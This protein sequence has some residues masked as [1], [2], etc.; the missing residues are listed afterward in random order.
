MLAPPLLVSYS[1]LEDY[2]SALSP[3]IRKMYEEEIRAL[4]DSQLPPVV[5]SRCLSVLFGYSTKFV[6]AL[7]LRNYKYY[8][9]FTIRKGNK[10]RKI[11]APRVALKVIQKWFGHHL[12]ETLPVEDYVYGFVSGRSAV[13]AA[14]QHCGASWVYSVDIENF[15]PSTN[16]D[17]VVKALKE[18]G[19]SE[20]GAR[21][22]TYL[23]CYGSY[24]GQG[25]PSSPVLS[26]LV[27]KPI[28][29]Q[30]KEV[31]DELGITLTRY[32]DDIVL[33][34]R[35]NIP[36]EL[37]L[38]V[39]KIFA[40]TCWKLAAKKEYLAEAKKGQRLKVH[41]LLVNGEVPRLTKGYRNRIRAYKHL[42]STDKVKPEDMRRIIGHI[43]FAESV[44]NWGA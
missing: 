28:D 42:L 2:L 14:A 21:L 38:R 16:D 22:I 10:R 33:S 34:G 4:V 27:M 32:A 23:C 5:S 25:A 1:S 17:L 36:E 24:L 44:E 11:Q 18:L 9:E 39:A 29:I 37:S 19:Y 13:D 12:A 26:N 3:E 43:K 30:L 35:E 31:A 15:F 8:R 7:A 6:N 40:S 41:G 20:K